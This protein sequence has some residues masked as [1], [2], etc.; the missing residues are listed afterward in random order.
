MEVYESQEAVL[1]EDLAPILKEEIE[2][3]GAV[4]SADS[5]GAA[6]EYTGALEVI[7]ERSGILGR[8]IYGV[9]RG[10][11]DAVELDTADRLLLAVGRHISEVQIVLR[12]DVKAVQG[13]RTDLI[14]TVARCRGMHVPAKGAHR[15]WTMKARRELL[16]E[17]V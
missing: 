13:E 7:A 14:R 1:A 10:E 16:K 5:Y 15:D 6:K 8:R 12:K 17:A 3:L 2:R 9:V 11:V 4:L